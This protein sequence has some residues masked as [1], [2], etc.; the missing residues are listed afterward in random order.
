MFILIYYS[1]YTVTGIVDNPDGTIVIQNKPPRAWNGRKF[2]VGIY[3]DGK[4]LVTQQDV[5]VG[6]QVDF[7]LQPRLYFAVCRNVMVGE[8]F[9]SLEITSYMKEF[10]LAN[11]PHGMQ[12]TL[13][14]AAG[15]GKYTFSAV[16]MN[17]W[18]D[19]KHAMFYIEYMHDKVCQHNFCFCIFDKS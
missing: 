12:V 7:M 16:N 8:I 10:D 5:H 15:G 3:K 14:E 1:N 11:Y 13:K 6:D 9:T 18:T 19:I 2:D 4:L 17:L